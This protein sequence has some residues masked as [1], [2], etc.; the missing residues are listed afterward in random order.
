M[1]EEMEMEEEII[2]VYEV[3]EIDFDYEFDA[4]RFFDFTRPESEAESRFSES[5]FGKAPSYPPSP[6]IAQ[7][8]G[9]N[10]PRVDVSP[11]SKYND[12]LSMDD[13]DAD[14]DEHTKY[15][16]QD[17]ARRE[18]SSQ[19]LSKT[20]C[21]KGFPNSQNQ[22]KCF[23]GGSSTGFTFFNH[24]AYDVKKTK[25]KPFAKPYTRK[26]STLMKPTASQLARQNQQHQASGTLRLQKN[27]VISGAHSGIESQASKRQK[28]DG[29]LRRIVDMKTPV[30]LTHKQ[31][32]KDAAVHGMNTHTKLRITIPR[33]PDFA[34]AHRAERFRSTSTKEMENP[35]A[36]TCR[37]KARPFTRKILEAPVP[38]FPRR[39]TQHLPDLKASHLK[40]TGRTNQHTSTS[41]SAP[42]CQNDKVLTKVQADS[43]LETG[44]NDGNRSDS[45]DVPKVAARQVVHSFKARPL[46]RKILTSRGDLGVFRNNKRDVTVPKEFEFHTAKR[47]QPNLPTELFSKLSL[48]GE[49]RPKNC[50]QI[51]VPQRTSIP[52]KGSKE[53]RWEPCQKNNQNIT[54]QA[55]GKQDTHNGKD[56][57]TVTNRRIGEVNP[58]NG[59]SRTLGSCRQQH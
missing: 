12:R 44:N 29:G 27:D 46:D 25:P 55:K 13:G 35:T 2:Q 23:Q 30:N 48:A 58:R 10:S 52:A 9:L 5:W 24:L 28:L 39:I 16:N 6:F 1:D 8:N 14:I 59:T 20:I 15:C 3:F 4:T 22:A 40:S 18:D 54:H 51:D 21:D 17:E 47:T 26:T 41:V 19:A 45:V 43:S 57:L 11:M 49:P 34:T 32:K 42:V 53:N 31:P 38:S 37:F 56:R 33:E 50:A 7:L 36:T